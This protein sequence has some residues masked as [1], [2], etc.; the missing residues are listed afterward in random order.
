MIRRGQFNPLRSVV[1][2]HITRFTLKCAVFCKRMYVFVVIH[3]QSEFT[4]VA[5]LPEMCFTE[6]EC[7]LRGTNLIFRYILG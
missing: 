3:Q 7:L 1:I 5:E 2:L 4:S 6:N